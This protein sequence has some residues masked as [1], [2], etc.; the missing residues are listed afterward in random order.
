MVIL[1]PCDKFLEGGIILKLQ[2]IPKGPFSATKL[3][4]LGRNRLGE[5]KERESEV[6]KPILV[7]LELILAINDLI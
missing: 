4:L 3:V 6:N 7:F 5:T 1:E 2:A